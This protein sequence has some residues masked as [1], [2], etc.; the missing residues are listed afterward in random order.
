MTKK[1]CLAIALLSMVTPLV[2]VV[3]DARFQGSYGVEKYKE[4]IRL[5]HNNSAN[6][7]TNPLR[8]ALSGVVT[9]I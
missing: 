7:M 3:P 5:R 2:A 9:V 4:P 8:I 1:V 6:A